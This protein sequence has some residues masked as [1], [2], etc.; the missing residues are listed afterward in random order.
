MRKAGKSLA[1][2]ILIT[3]FMCVL[4]G[5]ALPGTDNDFTDEPSNPGIQ[6]PDKPN[7]PIG[8]PSSGEMYE[9][10]NGNEPYFS[11]SDYQKAEG[12]YFIELSSLDSMGRV[13]VNMGLFDYSHMP[14][15]EREPLDTTPTGWVQKKYDTSIVPGGYIYNRS[16][17]IGFQISGLQDE[18]R[19]LMTGTRAFN[20]GDMSM[21]T[22]ENMTADHMK[23]NRNHQILYR[24]TPDF[25]GSNKLAH[26]ILMESDCLQCD[27]NADYCVYIKNQQK[28]IT[29]NYAT[30]DNWLDDDT[31][32]SGIGTYILNTSSKKFHELDCSRDRKSTR[33]NSSH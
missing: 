1:Y 11:S 15:G 14:T 28:G 13:G 21:L 25:K 18:K 7:P 19:N 33:L 12:G 23:E 20:A 31:P 17:L 27:D 3:F 5:C 6:D 32:S 4:I 8:E 2:F 26:G 30:G 22:F 16:H 10:R 24:V 29:I 9:I